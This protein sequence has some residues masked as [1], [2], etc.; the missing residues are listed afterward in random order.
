MNNVKLSR[1][2]EMSIK[3]PIADIDNYSRTYNLTG[4]L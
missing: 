1:P 3:I 2:R 4:K